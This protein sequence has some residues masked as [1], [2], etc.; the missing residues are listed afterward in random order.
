VADNPIHAPA[1][2]AIHVALCFDDG[3]WAPAYATIRSICLNTLRRG[4]LVFHLC[5]RTLAPEH[6]AELDAIS[7]EFGARLAYYDLDRINLS[8][9]VMERAPYNKRLGNI[10][11][12]RLLFTELLPKDVHR[13]VY[14][15]CDMLVRRP[16]EQLAEIDLRGHPLAAASDYWASSH[17]TQRDMIDQRKL[18]DIAN[19]YFNAGLLV[20]DLD[21]WRR[22]DVLGHFEA[23]IDDGTLAKIYYDQDFLNLMFVANWLELDQRWNFLNPRAIH[24]VLNPFLLHYTGSKK[25]WMMFSGVAFAREY[26]HVMTNA[27]FYRYLREQ[28][29]R[30]LPRFL[31]PLLIR[32]GTQSPR[33]NS[34]TSL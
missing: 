5:H 19:G 1:S 27:I 24:E 17:M 18:F 2:A 23:M 16:I 7:S 10:V 9:S 11:Y 28:W 33:R 29:A 6:K 13:L 31:R 32:R 22:L 26:R 4:D 15:D 12:A 25:P 20:I 34:A 21:S 14:L 3:Y 8:A 30:R